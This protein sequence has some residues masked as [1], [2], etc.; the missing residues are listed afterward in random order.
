MAMPAVYRSRTGVSGIKRTG[1][2]FLLHTR[3][4]GVQISGWGNDRS[5]AKIVT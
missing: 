4:R 3:S 1:T 2:T 5:L